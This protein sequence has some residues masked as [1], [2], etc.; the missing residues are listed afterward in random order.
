MRSLC[1]HPF[2]NSGTR[3]TRVVPWSDRASTQ[4]EALKQRQLPRHPA[5]RTKDQIAFPA[6]HFRA[7]TLVNSRR[8]RVLARS[9]RASGLRCGS[10]GQM[11]GPFSGERH[12]VFTGTSARL[13][14][15]DFA[16]REIEVV[17]N[18]VA[19]LPSSV[20]SHSFSS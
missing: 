3:L 7:A 2:D 12:V 17:S 10:S 9:E 15:S 18:I 5:L 8:H 4:R 19:C 14:M 11:E 20:A 6:E 1:Y 16:H 13:G